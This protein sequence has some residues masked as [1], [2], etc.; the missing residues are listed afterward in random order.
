MPD[1]NLVI[2]RNSV[3]E[4]VRHDPKRVIKIYGSEKDTLDKYFTAADQKI[5]RENKIPFEYLHKDEITL[6]SKS[7]SH[8][9]LIAVTKRKAE[10][11]I[12]DYLKLHTEE[13]SLVLMLDDIQDPQNLGAILR[14]AECFA[15]DLVIY[16]KNKGAGITPAVTKASVGASELLNIV[17]VSNLADAIG[18]FKDAGYWAILADAD[19]ESGSLKAFEFPKKTLLIMGSEGYG[20]Q[21]LIKKEVDFK[22]FIDLHGRISSLNVSQATAIMLDSYRRQFSKVKA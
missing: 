3:R 4:V 9:S 12:K 17:S 19:A 14:A 10:I 13:E 21:P 22:L 5:I 20:A 6:I 7:D 15:V 18:K 1:G 16:S 8:Q 2:G 11:G